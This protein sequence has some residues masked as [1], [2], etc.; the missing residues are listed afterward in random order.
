MRIIR[1]V[2]Q[3]QALARLWQR[4]GRKVGFVP[5]MGF[6]H[7]GHASLMTRARKRVGAKGI[8]VV[9]IFVNPTQFAPT[10]D[11][12]KYPRD[13]SGDTRLCR[14][15][16]VDVVFVPTDESMYPQAGGGFSTFVEEKQVS[17]GME[18]ASRPTHF[19]GVATV[20]AKL[21]NIV[22]PSVA[23]FGAKDFQQ[24][25]VIQKMV[26]DLNFPVDIDVA[27]TIREPDGLA[28]SSRNSYLSIAGRQQALALHD[29]IESAKAA[30]STGKSL[31]PE[32]L[33]RKLTSRIEKRPNAQV[34]YIAFFDAETLL[35]ARKVKKGVRM[36]LA[37]RVEKTRL[38]DND[39]L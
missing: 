13:L 4:T 7:K 10:E 5:T 36:A 32:P 20:V 1:D 6:L 33:I 16:G 30:V 19:R 27:E 3:M 23:I 39:Q 17:Q 8:V 9:S 25:A 38:I 31:N 37:V 22:Q 35:P 34:D 12:T 29:A 15:R 18:G 11:L 21:F 26:A 24:A 14:S 2:T 28:M